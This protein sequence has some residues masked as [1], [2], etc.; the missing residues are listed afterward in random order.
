VAGHRTSGT[1]RALSFLSEVARADGDVPAARASATEALAI[2][3]ELGDMVGATRALFHRADVAS[4]E[5]DHTEA[6]RLHAEC[7]LALEELGDAA[8]LAS[9][10][11]SL[12][13][14]VVALGRP[15]PAATVLGAA[16]ALRE[17]SG[18]PAQPLYRARLQRTVAAARVALGEAAFEDAWS[19]GRAMTPEQAVAGVLGTHEPAPPGPSAPAHAPTPAAASPLTRREREVATLVARGASIARSPASW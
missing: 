13:W 4:L 7:A 17:R 11:E 15:G 9:C 16:D 1:A 14:S 2:M 8:S 10:L 12:A 5:G 19:L 6:S 3:R 18:G